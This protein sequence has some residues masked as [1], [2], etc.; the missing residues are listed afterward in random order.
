MYPPWALRLSAMLISIDDNSWRNDLAIDNTGRTAELDYVLVQPNQ[1]P[2][3][4]EWQR[5]I[6]RNPEWDGP[7]GRDDLSY[8]YAVV[9]SIQFP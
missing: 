9:A 1:V 8:R 2:L 3:R 4:T 5:L 6:M 7:G